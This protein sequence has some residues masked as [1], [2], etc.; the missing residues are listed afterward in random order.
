MTTYHIDGKVVKTENAKKCWEEAT[1]WNGSNHISVNTGNQ[2]VH[3][4]LYLSKKGNYYIE[5]YSDWQGSISSAEF[6]T[7]AKA[8]KWLL[9]NNYE[10]PEHLK[11]YQEEI[12]E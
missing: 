6:V 8:A 2:W 9:F 10:L 3:E 1:R 4:T 11:K 5:S 12:E 7:E